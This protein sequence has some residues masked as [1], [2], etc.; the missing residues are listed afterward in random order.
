MITNRP[1]VELIRERFSCRSYL[2]EPIAADKQ[3]GL[4]NL[5]KTLTVGPLGTPLRFELIAGE[6]HDPKELRGLGTYGFIKGA[7]GFILGTVSPGV[8]DMEDHGYQLEQIVL[9]AT[10]LGLGTCWLG[11]TF[12]VALMKKTVFP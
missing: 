11:G 10:A 4:K 1:I 8:R 5:M 6:A 7:S 9:F 3:S 2:D 12:C